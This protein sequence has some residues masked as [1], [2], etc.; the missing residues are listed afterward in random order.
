MDYS[1][2]DVLVFAPLAPLLALILFWFIQLLM[3][4]SLKHQLSKIW[5]NHGALCRFSNFMGVLFQTIAHV[6]GY[7]L[8]GIGVAEFSLSVDDSRVSPKRER[9]GV[10]EWIANLFLTLGPFFIPSFVVFLLLLFSPDVYAVL[11]NLVVDDSFTFSGMLISFG[12]LLH[13]FGVAFLTFLIN[14]DLFN[15]FHVGFLVLFLF[16]G[17]GI[18]PSY[19]GEERRRVSMLYDLSM[20]KKMLTNHPVYVIATIAVIYIIF[21]LFFLLKVQF[22]VIFFSFLGW[23]SIIAIVAILAAHVLVMMFRVSDLLP[24]YKR[25]LPFVVPVVSY[26]ILRLFFL[27]FPTSLQ[28]SLSLV[29]TVVATVVVSI[30]LLEFETNKLKMFSKIGQRKGEDV[31]DEKRG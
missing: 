2:V 30:L 13:Q 21:Y 10:P 11:S 6:A 19:I 31:E 12:S 27:V 20:I 25:F 4:E 23:L 1:L 26:I 29:L 18:R 5:E 3:I 8:T 28:Y 14:L 16:F 9:K 22:Y 7:T 24:S 15:P 17:L